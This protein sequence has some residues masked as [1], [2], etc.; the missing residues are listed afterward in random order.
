MTDHRSQKQPWDDS[1]AVLTAVVALRLYESCRSV[2][3]PAECL[4]AI[5]QAL[6]ALRLARA[7]LRAELGMAHDMR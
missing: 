4:D 5:E 2:N 7:A 1:E 3:Q 6:T